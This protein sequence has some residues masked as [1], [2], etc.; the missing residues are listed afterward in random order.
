[1]Q[2]SLVAGGMAAL[3]GLTAFASWY[4]PSERDAEASWRPI[5]WPF[6]RDAWP[7]GRAWRHQDAIGGIEVHV[8]PKLGFCGNCETGVVEDSEVDRVT[9]IE[10]MDERFT[11]LQEGRPVRIADLAGRARLY[12]IRKGGRERLA[13]GIAVSRKC[14]LVVAV[15][16]GDVA[17]ETIRESAHRFLAS[18]TVQ[19]WITAVLEGR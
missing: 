14:D 10:L 9:D 4:P 12:R 8:R 11:P 15:V 5:A 17:D 13:E 1:M 16:V 2:T 3:A 18:N 6:P 7:P 19:V